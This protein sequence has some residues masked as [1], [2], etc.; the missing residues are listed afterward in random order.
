MLLHIRPQ[1][2][3]HYKDVALID[4]EI[5]PFGLRLNGHT[6]LATRRP[7]PNKHYAVACRRQGRKA[8][9]G[10]LIETRNPVAEFRT[11]ARWAVGAAFVVSHHVLYTILDRDFDAA[12]DCMMLWHACSEYGEW[13]SRTPP[14]YSRLAPIKIQP[15]MEI[16]AQETQRNPTT[17]DIVDESRRIITTRHETF[18]MPTIERERILYPCYVERLPQLSMAFCVP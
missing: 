3:S 14:Q 12:S 11:T 13:S 6:D 2:Y 9:N 1:L 8:V 17:T 10:M 4:L 16:V 15:T 18:A 7:H 5:Q